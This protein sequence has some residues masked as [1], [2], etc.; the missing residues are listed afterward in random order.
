MLASYR[1]FALQARERVTRNF[2]PHLC[3][4]LLQAAWPKGPLI[5]GN[6]R[7]MDD[8]SLLL[9]YSDLG[10]FGFHGTFELEPL[11]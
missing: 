10:C 6:A 2:G 5:D 1:I 9:R 7:L 3:V 4:F 8:H 11:A